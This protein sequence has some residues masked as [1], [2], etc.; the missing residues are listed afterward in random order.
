MNTKSLHILLE[1][2]THTLLEAARALGIPLRARL[3]S[4]LLLA[5]VLQL[6]RIDIH[7][8]PERK[9]SACDAHKFLE[10][11]ARRAQGEPI[12]YIIQSVSFYGRDFYVDNRVLIPRPETEM[13]VDLASTLIHTY[14][15]HTVVEVGVGSGALIA[16][17][18]KIHPQ[19]RFIG[20]DISEEAL[21]VARQNVEKAKNINLLHCS[22]LDHSAL[23]A[24]KQYYMQENDLQ[25]ICAT[26]DTC[27]ELIISNPPYIADDYPIS[28]PLRYEPSIALFGGSDGLDILYSL[29]NEAAMR[30]VW[31]LCEMGYDQKER[32]EC[33][34]HDLNGQ[35]VQFYKD[36]NGFWRGFM[37][38][39]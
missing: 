23:S 2:A 32:I 21:A 17:L 27:V 16:T 9:V 1:S 29:I 15:F 11:V 18:A 28:I 26:R 19:C 35:D 36:L 30:K 14:D 12:E 22:L 34:L 37:V 25:K 6:S 3:E 31:L 38:K 4:E 33:I 13:L 7:T 20:T 24:D 8:H 10:Y 39:F 5:H